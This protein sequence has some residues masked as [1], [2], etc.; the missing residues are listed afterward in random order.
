MDESLA[1]KYLESIRK[2][3]N[4]VVILVNF[5]RELFSI[6]EVDAEIYKVFA[7]LTKIY[8]G[9]NI[10]YA[11]LDCTDVENLDTSSIHRLI[12]F[13]AKKRLA[14]KY[15]EPNIQ[16]LDAELKTRATKL[17]KVKNYD[18]KNPFN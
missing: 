14:A 1:E 2:T 12:A 11:L 7:R 18:V 15:T 13:F 6:D 10:F 17:N 4:G 3:N 16:S 5:Y 8:G 9:E